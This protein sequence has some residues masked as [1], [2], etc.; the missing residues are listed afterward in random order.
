MD[1]TGEYLYVADRDNNAIRQLDLPYD[2][3][4]TAITNL[5]SKPV[6]V[7]VD[8]AGNIYVL[9][10]GNGNNGSVLEF[11]TID[12]QVFTLI[13]TNAMN[14]TNAAGM[15]LDVFGNIYV[16]IKSN[17]VLKITSPGVSNVVATVT[18]AGAFLQGIVLKRSGPTAGLLAVCDSGRNGIYLID[19][20]SGNITTNSGFH[21]V[22]DFNQSPTPVDTATAATA[23]FDQPMGI[24]EAG[25]GSLI[26]TDNGN[27]R[28]KVVRVS[29]GTVTNL[30][31]VTSTDWNWAGNPYPG[32]SSYLHPYDGL[33][34]GRPKFPI[35]WVVSRRVC[36]TVLP[37]GLTAQFIQRKIITT[38]SA[39]S[40][41]TTSRRRRPGRRSAPTGP[42][43]TAGYGQV[44]LSWT[45]SLGA[46]NY[47]VKRSTTNNAEVTI[48]STPGTTY[49]DTN[50]LDGTTYYYVVSALNVGGEG[51][52]RLKSAPNRCFL[53]RQP[54]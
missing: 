38:S 44:L 35:R 10:R 2:Q 53:P 18:N 1:S 37:L 23:K 33:R 16:T 46:T 26:V 31:G 15:A 27:H 14:L 43:A 34:R 47:N 40:R 54:A 9:N 21:G 48:A 29:D 12:N 32:F 49:S 3:T 6:G 52:T 8:G 24:A 5:I 50:V 51:R 11:S 28:V 41:E 45:A 39:R 30:Y 20:A 19:P 7:A 42:F 36:P 25:D 4:I 22:G 13:A 17:T